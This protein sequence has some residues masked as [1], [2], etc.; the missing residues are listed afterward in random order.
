[1][2]T[3][4]SFG[5]LPPQYIYGR[6]ATLLQQGTVLLSGGEHEDCGRY[7]QAELYDAVSTKFTATGSMTRARDNHTATLLRDGTVLTAGGESQ[8]G[9]GNGAWI[10]SGTTKSAES[11]DPSTR[12]FTS[13]GDMTERR[14]GHTATL[15]NDGRVLITGGY[16]YAGIG[17]Y[18][19]SF[20]SAEIYTPAVLPQV[21]SVSD[22]RFD[23]STAVPGSSFTANISGSG[24]TPDTFFDVRFTGPGSPRSAVVLNWQRGTVEDHQVPAGLGAGMWTIN[25]VRAHKIETDHTGNFFPVSATITVS[26]PLFPQTLVESNAAPR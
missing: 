2:I 7:A 21:L 8:E 25:G 15:L 20:A 22:L 19:G 5:N 23:Q 24:L 3:P 6:T 4:C 26:N 10:F 14:A 9:F 16:G 17:A 11:Y 13:V 12:G 18:L 1:M